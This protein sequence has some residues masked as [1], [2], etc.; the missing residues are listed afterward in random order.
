MTQLADSEARL[1]ALTSLDKSYLIEAGAGSGKTSLLAGR[2]VAL[3][4]KGVNPSNIVSVSFTELAASELL[5]RIF[6]FATSLIEGKV[7]PDI[8]QAFPNGL[9]ETQSSNLKR[10]IDDIGDMTCTTIHGFC[11]KLLRPYPV[12]AA[13]DPGASILDPGDADLIFNDVL[14]KWMRK[15][16]SGHDMD[17]NIITAMVGHDPAQA[18]ETIRSIAQRLKGNPDLTAAPASFTRDSAKAFFD[19]V[20]ALRA[21]TAIR[22]SVP[23]DHASLLEAW[24]R[25][26]SDV[27]VVVGDK[28]HVAVVKLCA[29]QP[30]QGISLKSG[31]Y[32]GYR[33][34]TA[35]KAVDKLNA[36]A[37][38][39][40]GLRLHTEC[41]TAFERLRETAAAAALFELESAV[42]PV[43]ADYN[44]YKRESA[45][46]DF[47]DLLYRTRDLLA[48]NPAILQSMREFYTHILVDEFQD[49]DPVQA[50]IFRMLAFD[51]VD[52]IERPRPGAIF[53]VG[54][55]KQSIYR[56]RGADV[57]TYVWMR[58]L[59]RLADPS[60]VM[61]IFVNFRSSEGIIA[62]VNGVFEAPLSDVR[63]PGFTHLSSH[64]GAFATPAVMKYEATVDAGVDER[65]KLEAERT[66]DAVYNLITSYKIA[67]KDG[68]ERPCQAGD[69]ALLAPVNT[70]LFWLENAL[71]DRGIP[72]STQ[73][74]KGLFQQQEVKDLIALTRVLADPRD[75]LALGALLRGSFF[76]FTD[77]EL[78]DISH[79]LPGQTEERIAF[80]SL[81]TDPSD[82]ADPLMSDVIATLARLRAEAV[83]ST[84]FDVLSRAIDCFDIRAKTRNKSHS[85]ASRRLSNIERYLD[86]CRSYDV[87]GLRA[88]SDSMREKWENSERVQEGRPGG[89]ENSVSIITIHSSKGL[90]WPVV[91][92][93]NCGTEFNNRQTMFSD[94]RNSTF[95]MKFLKQKP[96]GFD[97]FVE[98]CRAEDHAERL[99]L[100]YVGLTRARDLLVIPDIVSKPSAK[101]WS[102]LVDTRIETLPYIDAPEN[103]API[104]TILENG[105]TVSRDQHLALLNDISRNRNF[106]RK[107]VPSGHEFHSGIVETNALDDLVE[108]VPDMNPYANIEG[109]VERGNILHKLMEEVV[110]R[111][112]DISHVNER[113]LELIRQV[114]TAKDGKLPDLH[115]DEIAACVERTVGLPEI[116]AILPLLIT[117]IG[118]S[119]SEMEDNIETLTLGVADAV[120]PREGRVEIVVDWKGDLRPS[121]LAVENYTKQVRRYMDVSGAARGLIVFM[122]T[123]RVVEVRAA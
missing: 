5:G 30:D 18:V 96:T 112:T 101:S 102:D 8:R 31:G 11:Q 47:D 3:M 117:E 44:L 73:A 49:T 113:A 50:S 13:I 107:R 68:S 72:V 64:R 123:G 100:M 60:S 94:V 116:A 70:N 41:C 56:F 63:Q 65:R 39:E 121:T 20:E 45:L 98:E 12:E 29:L 9:S 118:V 14:D 91:F 51:T 119:S 78:L 6:E 23:E 25:M 92:M 53:F 57:A 4:V 21:W 16:M 67:V 86:L 19:A 106:V 89:I 22:G 120:V 40:E 2:V 109:G 74:G 75:T 61:S 66:A 97:D 42:R 103:R 10:A 79:A 24:R 88:F 122:T 95:A 115:A 108:A 81:A 71:E 52:G 27:D 43:L 69:I 104:R 38:N 1:I 93:V 77:R 17:E 7:P 55:P 58:E 35:W 80:L 26:V 76:G 62:Y 36:N 83:H 110:N 85:N 59:M 99:R 46:L 54:D 37:F 82:I 33:M 87:R 105:E 111:E 90:E 32:R 28:P 114:T 34:K 15:R 48:Q 84:P